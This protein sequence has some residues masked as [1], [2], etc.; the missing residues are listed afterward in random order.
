M[1]FPDAPHSLKMACGENPKRVYGSKGQMPST[2]MGNVAGY[3]KSWIRAEAYLSKLEEYEAKSD[4]AKEMGY[5]PSRD[6]ELD[7]L[8]GVLRGDILV[9]NHCY[10]AEEM[11]MMIDIAMS[12]I[13]AISS[14][15]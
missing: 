5:R 10:R 14:A 13:I 4:E 1:K 15:L 11:A 8:A 3:R 6:L 9:Q 12:I 7:T 2:R